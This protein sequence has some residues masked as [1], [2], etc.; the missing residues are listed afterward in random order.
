MVEYISPLD[1]PKNLLIL[2]RKVSDG[3]PDAQREYDGLLSRLGIYPAIEREC[4]LDET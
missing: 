2:A 4:M 3:N 1:T